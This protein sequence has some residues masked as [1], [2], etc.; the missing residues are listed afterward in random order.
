MTATVAHMSV[1][2]SRDLRNHTAEILG[3]VSEGVDVTV[4]VH[5]RPVAVIT[6]PRGLRPRSWSKNEFLA[7]REHALADAGLRVD[8]QWISSGTTDELDDLG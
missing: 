4:T 3:R 8:L 2:A 5:G 1:V 6:R 7:Q